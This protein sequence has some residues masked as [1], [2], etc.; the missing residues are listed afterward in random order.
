M[1]YKDTKIF[2]ALYKNSCSKYR[3][4]T[5]HRKANYVSKTLKKQL[6]ELDIIIQLYMLCQA[7]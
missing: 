1:L 4:L 2:T 7:E 6:K 5:L 3:I